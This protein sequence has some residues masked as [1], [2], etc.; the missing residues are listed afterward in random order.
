[1]IAELLL[2][3]NA[4]L[5]KMKKRTFLLVNLPNYIESTFHF[6]QENDKN[7]LL[8]LMWLQGHFHLARLNYQKALYYFTLCDQILSEIGSHNTPLTL[9]S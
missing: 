7:Y 9:H 4:S 8:R 2:D 3:H 6:V 5:A 1:M